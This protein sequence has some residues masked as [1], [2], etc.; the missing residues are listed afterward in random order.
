M[1]WSL[2]M[3]PNP[4]SGGGPYT[5]AAG[6]SGT[7]DAY[8]TTLATNLSAAGWNS[9][10][11]MIRLG[12]EFNGNWAYWSAPAGQENNFVTY[13]RNIVTAMRA[14]IPGLRFIWSPNM[15]NNWGSS[16]LENYYPGSAYV[17]YVGMDVYDT[18]SGINSTTW[19]NYLT[20][21]YGL[22]WLAS[23]SAT[24]GKPLCIPEFGLGP[25]AV[26]E[27]GGGRDDPDFISRIVAWVS[28][29]SP[30]GYVSI[31]DPTDG[32]LATSWAVPSG[33]SA[34]NSNEEFVNLFH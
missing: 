28:A 31:W 11:C 8:F 18:E 27:S 24:T 20:M 5:L 21:S 15:G 4:A 16:A 9:K 14:L 1:V 12:W 32:N 33:K 13:W 19:N 2:P 17:N 29:N 3:L 26:S 6:A 23:F 10:N 30:N 34:P 25:A 22:N 7:Y